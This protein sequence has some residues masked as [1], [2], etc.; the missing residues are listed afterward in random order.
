MNKITLLCR[1]TLVNQF[2]KSSVIGNVSIITKSFCSNPNFKPFENNTQ[3]D[4]STERIVNV[5][6]IGLPNAGKSTLINN[7]ID[8]KVTIIKLS[9]YITLL[10]SY[11]TKT[12]FIIL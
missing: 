3:L 12:T 5:A 11:I 8:R 6:V 9:Y 2:I 4:D 10:L 7:L 1:S